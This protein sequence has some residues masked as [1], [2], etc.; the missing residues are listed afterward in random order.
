VQQESRHAEVANPIVV[1]TLSS[2]CLSSACIIL[3]RV[4]N[5]LCTLLKKI[6]VLR[7]VYH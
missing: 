6:I 4:C 5:I 1:Y 2:T 7:F 3:D